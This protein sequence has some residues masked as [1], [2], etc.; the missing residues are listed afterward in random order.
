[1]AELTRDEVMKRAAAKQTFARA[2]LR[3]LDLSNA[4]LE[5]LDFS[6]AELDGEMR[7]GAERLA[8]ARSGF[9]WLVRSN[10]FVRST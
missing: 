2:D 1:M 5:G 7:G 4:M 9:S 8:A 3:G 10:R 6:R